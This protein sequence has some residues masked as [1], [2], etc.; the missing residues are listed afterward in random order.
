MRYLRVIISSI[1]VITLLSSYACAEVLYMWTDEEGVVHIIDN[2]R[3]LPPEDDVE[4][5]SY[6]DASDREP[7]PDP[8]QGGQQV[9][10]TA[11]EEEAT[12]VQPDK[13]PEEEAR[14]QEL[15]LK[16]EKAREEYERAKERVELRRRD[17]SRKSTRHNRDQYKHALEV[18]AEKR[19]KIRELERLK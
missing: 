9:M 11:E 5:I 2:P 7:L 14:A 17:Y 10:E 13:S 12:S 18:L 1:F 15:E 3:R 6:R 19:E 16:L 4:R 8:G